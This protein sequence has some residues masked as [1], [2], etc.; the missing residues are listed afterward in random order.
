[1]RPEPGAALRSELRAGERVERAAQV[2]HRQALVH[3]QA[4]DLM[5][6][7]GVGGVQLVGAEGAADRDDV[8][9]QV[10]FEQRAD[11]HRR[12][13]G[14]QHLPRSVRR[15]VEGVLLAARRMVGREV[16]RVEVEL[17]GLDLGSLGQLP[18]HRDEGVGDVLGEDRDRVPRADRLTGR[19]Q[20]HVDA[21]GDQHRGVALGPQ[22]L[23]SLVVA[24]LRLGADDVD[25]L[26]RVGS[27]GLRQRSQRLPCQRERRAV[28]QVLGLGARQGVE[29]AGQIEGM[30][31][32]R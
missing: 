22:H 23:Q 2:G 26:A 27:I 15:D 30:L 13:V 1:M 9:R 12:G 20:R 14:A 11:L 16:E 18:A 8:D 25:P 17:L 28:A 7:R 10:A 29:V 6:D 3:R 4:L 31:G 5:E 32:P 24:A 19:R 21:L